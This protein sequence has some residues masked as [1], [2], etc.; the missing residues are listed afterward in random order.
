MADITQE[1]AARFAGYDEDTGILSW[2]VNR[3]TAKKGNE[4]GCLRPDGYRRINL[5]GKKY[6]AHHLIWLL[7]YGELPKYTIEHANGI[8]DDNRLSNLR[9]TARKRSGPS[10]TKPAVKK[11]LVTKEYPVFDFC[12]N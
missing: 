4:M 2:Q 10:K 6:L 7:V 12:L 8:K 9:E 5:C 11:P 1:E 3:G